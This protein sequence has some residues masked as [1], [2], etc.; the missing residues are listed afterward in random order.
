MNIVLS[1][2]VGRFIEWNTPRVHSEE[3]KAMYT[4]AIIENYVDLV[5]EAIGMLIWTYFIWKGTAPSVFFS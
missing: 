2:L 1:I 5:L 4:F 3:S